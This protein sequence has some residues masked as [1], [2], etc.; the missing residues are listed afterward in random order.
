MNKLLE[1]GLIIGAVTSVGVADVLIKKIF[2]PRTTF[3]TDIKNPLMLAVIILYLVQIVIF[4]YIFDRKA[5]LGIVGIIQTALYA[6]IV[7]GSGLL[8]FNEDISLVQGIG[9]GVAILGVVLMNL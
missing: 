8:F 1:M 7:I 6:I 2:L 9:I 5:E 3:F 4:A